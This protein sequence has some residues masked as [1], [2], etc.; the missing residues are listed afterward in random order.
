MQSVVVSRW[1]L[2]IVC[3]A[4]LAFPNA[5]P[6][7]TVYNSHD[8]E[9]YIALSKNLLE[10]RGYTRSLNDN[11]FIPHT[12]WPPGMAVLLAPAVALSGDTIN[13]YYVKYSIIFL[14]LLGIWLTRIYLIRLLDNE[15]IANW[16]VLLLALNP[17]FWH[18]SRIAMAEIPV[19]TWGIL[20]LLLID[21]CF[22]TSTT[23]TVK[24]MTLG[25]VVGLGMLLKGALVG[26]LLAPLPYLWRRGLFSLL[27]I[28]QGL[29]YAICFCVPFALWMMSN[30]DIDKSNLGFDGVNQIQMIT[31]K[32]IE[33]PLSEYKT[34][35]EIVITAKQNLLWHAIYH[36]P[37][38]IIPGLFLAD[39]GNITM[40]NI[41]AL[42]LSM[43]IIA[44]IISQF[45]L[46]AP[47]IL[48]LCPAVILISVMTI[49]GAERY[50]FTITSLL[51]IVCYLAPFR[52]INN[53]KLQKALMYSLVIVQLSSLTLFIY[54]HEATPYT[55][56]EAHD[57]LAKLFY[58]AKNLCHSKALK[59]NSNTWTKNEHAF[60]LMTGCKASMVNTAIGRNP[61]FTH[62]ALD[63]PRV[64][65]PQPKLLIHKGQ[66]GL[67]KLPRP[68]TEQQ[69]KTHYYDD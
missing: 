58:E 17:Y 25:L 6:D 33:D 13:F 46:L 24:L 2:L 42:I 1:L 66:Y 39:M 7:F 20:S 11:E 41:L 49:G 67:V 19:F 52:I 12:L 62:A 29:I 43:A 36:I 27:S 31:K 44:L 9:N 38:H 18:F 61:V 54:R 63:L 21:Q 47:L 57:Q 34:V 60:Q 69:I 8:A 30:M 26:L 59:G 48:S 23:S 15:K 45:R 56:V 22:K 64:S 50:W 3:A 10:G 5:R 37:N 16:V 65:Q 68:M 28:K 40:G 53:P 51:L 32:V 35:S 14:A 55:T 4:Y